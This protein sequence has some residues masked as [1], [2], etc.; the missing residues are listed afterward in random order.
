MKKVIL[1]IP[2]FPRLYDPTIFPPLGLLYIGAVLK[3]NNF[4]VELFDLRENFD[5]SRIPKAD[6]YGVTGHVT[7]VSEIRQ[8]GK[9]LEGKG[10]RIIGGVHATHM[11]E[12]FVGY[13]D[14][15]LRGDGEITVLDI[16]NNNLKGIIQGKT[17]E[18]I[19]TVPFP[20]RDLLPRDRIVSKD[21]IGGFGYSQDS[22]EAT[23][24]Y[25]SRGCPF[26]CAFCSNIPQPIRFHSPEYV[27]SEIK[28]VIDNYSVTSFNIMDDHFTM[29]KPRLRKLADLLEP[30][31]IEFKCMSR[32]ETLND[33]MCTLLKRMGC[34]E[35]QM[36]L[37]SADEKVL[38][39]MNKSLNLQQA[40]EAIAKVK[41]YGMIAKTFL[42]TGL[43]GE[44]WESIEKTKQFIRETQPDKCPAT[45]FMP[46]PVCDVWKNPDKYGVKILTR[47]Y[48]K[49][50]FR[51][52]T[53]SVI[54][55]KECSSE[56]LTEHFN[57]LRDYIDSNKWR[58]K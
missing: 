30:L 4:D 58:E 42:I 51:Y 49:Y 20:A 8:I 39:L 12:D 45:L 17:V 16:I 19:D 56:E 7:E 41:K 21:A 5:L 54:E 35:V 48:S 37:E 50:F 15:I 40:R 24:L 25:T 3:K 33:E 43:P 26:K 32:M 18:N 10:L 46:F 29:N 9:Y 53:E 27:L 55:T 52:P 47:E 1:I 34:I 13:F 28:F 6:V 36:G 23:V 14:T 57:N 38:K 11:P 31:K 2:P 44:T 22:H